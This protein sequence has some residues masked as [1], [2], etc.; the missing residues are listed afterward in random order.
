MAPRQK[1]QPDDT[2]TNTRAEKRPKSRALAASSSAAEAAPTKPPPKKLSTKTPPTPKS[3]RN[4]DD[5]QDETEEPTPEITPIKK[6]RATKKPTSTTPTPA[7]K[8]PT[9]T[10]TIP[11]KK[12]PT[13][14]TPTSAKKTTVKAGGGPGASSSKTMKSLIQGLNSPDDSPPEG[15][16]ARH[17]VDSEEISRLR[18]QVQKQRQLRE[19][20]RHARERA[21]AELAGALEEKA[22]FC[23]AMANQNTYVL[24]RLLCMIQSARPEFA[25]LLPKGQDVTKT[26][27]RQKAAD[28]KSHFDDDLEALQQTAS[29]AAEA[30]IQASLQVIGNQIDARPSFLRTDWQPTSGESSGNQNRLWF[31]GKTPKDFFRPLLATEESGLV[32]PEARVHQFCLMNG[33]TAPEKVAVALAN[34]RKQQQERDPDNSN[35][36]TEANSDSDMLYSEDEL[37]GDQLS[38]DQSSEDGSFDWP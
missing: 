27:L 38:E 32:D 25:D 17:D 8:K 12:K 11:A 7:K 2:A 36:S 14:T 33:I 31:H 19:G 3:K 20:E 37:S 10:T 4:K 35:V 16:K 9:S 23:Y 24:N 21:E 5:S 30:G 28:L 15:E 34:W 22:V 13:S 29:A 1:R 26:A 18:A 6:L